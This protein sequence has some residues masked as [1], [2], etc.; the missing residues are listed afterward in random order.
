[1]PGVPTSSQ[2]S[3]VTGPSSGPTTSPTG[4]DTSPS[5]GP[6]DTSSGPTSPTSSPTGPGGGGGPVK[7][8]STPPAN[9]K[10][11]DTY[12]LHASGG[13]GDQIVFSIGDRTTHSACSMDDAGTT[14]TFDH[15]GRCVI[16]AQDSGSSRSGSSGSGSSRSGSATRD[17]TDAV[18]TIDVA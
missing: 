4:G 12:R 10:F 13:S 17:S 5:G 1:T 14:V 9:P 7:F 2:T 8:T 16:R 18:Q 15:A 3:P 6:T 11:G